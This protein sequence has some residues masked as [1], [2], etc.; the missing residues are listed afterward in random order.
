MVALR[1]EGTTVAVK[2]PPG[3]SV[4]IEVEFAAAQSPRN[5]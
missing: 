3:G 5:G 4:V 2:V 1:P